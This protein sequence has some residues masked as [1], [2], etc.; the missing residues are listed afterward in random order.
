VEAAAERALL[1]KAFR[2]QSVKSILKNSLDM[3]PLSP[4]PPGSPPL[5]MTMFAGL[6]TSTK[7]G[8]L[9]AEPTTDG[10]ATGHALAR[11]GEG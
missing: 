5:T 3:V 1:A 10:K 6:S 8:R 9:H 11:H 7:E 2:Y 4:P